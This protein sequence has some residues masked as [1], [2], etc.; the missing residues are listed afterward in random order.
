MNANQ[1]PL[2]LEVVGLD[3]PDC[4]RS[5]ESA[6]AA[7]PGVRQAQLIYATGRL[8]VDL[9]AAHPARLEEIVAL[10]A[11]LGHTVRMRTTLQGVAESPR[12]GWAAWLRARR[13]DWDVLACGGLLVGGFIAQALGA[14]MPWPPLLFSAAILVG[15]RRVARAAWQALRRARALDMNALMTIAVVGAMALGEF[16][17]GAMTIL[18][19]SIGEWL[20]GYSADRARRAVRALVALAPA[21]ATRLV[22]GREERAP[23]EALVVGDLLLVRPGERIPMDGVIREGHSAVDQAPIT[24]ESLPVDKGPGAEVYAGS[25]NG[26]GALTVQ[27]SRLSQ[28]NTLSRILRLVEEAQGQ[29]APTQRFVDRFARVYTPLV[30]AA[31]LL[32]AVVPPL[33]GLGA[34]REWLYRGLVLLVIACPCALVISTPVTIVSALARAARSGVLIKGGRHLESLAAVR[35]IAFDKT[36]TLTEGRVQIVGGACALHA[37][38]DENCLLCRDM[39]AKAAAVEERSEHLLAR[40][41]VAHADAQGLRGHYPPSEEVTAYPG[42]GVVGAVEGHEIAIGSHSFGHEA[43]QGLDDPLCRQIVAAEEQG[44]TVLVARDACCDQRCFW[45]VADALRPEAPRAVAALRQLGLRQVA[46]L[47]GDNRQVAERVAEAIGSDQTHAGLLPQKKLALIEALQARWGAV[48]M[49]GDGINDAPALARA[50]VGIAMGGAGADAALE[51]ADVTLMG[52]DLMRLPYAIALSQRAMR[53]VRANIA[54]ALGLKAIFMLLAVLGLSTL[55]MAVL[56]DT[57]AALLVTLN[58][59]RLLMQRSPTA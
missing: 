20:E 34:L 13:S 39:L 10:G 33:V 24:G 1:N 59:L 41:V 43:C 55:W 25:I 15:G 27:V 17:E 48:A 29:R 22:E 6:V 44:Y 14:A 11:S 26:A 36:G 19:F 35:A 40:A 12:G 42:Q 45:A 18:L 38:A 16:A 58:G 21:E 57:G 7:L 37:Q 52:D 50:S 2:V 53:V 30:M 3:C 23:V 28:D 9:D 51:T 8:T 5:L 46:I 32:V 4:A 47:T 49:V 56:A 54:F 31:A